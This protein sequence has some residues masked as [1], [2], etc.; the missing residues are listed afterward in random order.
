[1]AG[2]ITRLIVSMWLAVVGI[3]LLLFGGLIR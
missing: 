2:M 3:S 1:V